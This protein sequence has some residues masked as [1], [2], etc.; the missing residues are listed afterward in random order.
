MYK[1]GVHYNFIGI[2]NLRVY[3]KT[4]M[5]KFRRDYRMS[6]ERDMELIRDLLIEFKGYQAGSSVTADNEKE[7]YHIYLLLESG[8]IEAKITNYMGGSRSFDNLHI[9][10]A[11]HDFIDAAQNETVWKKTKDVL[12]QKGVEISGVP[13]GVLKELL[14]TKMKEY[15]GLQ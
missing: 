12:K 9:T 6:M 14:K 13:I 15:I 7:D 11:G 8:L 1:R 4:N 10:T 5:F 3:Y 2:F